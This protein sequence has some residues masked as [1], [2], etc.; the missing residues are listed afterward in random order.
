MFAAHS[1]S[2]FGSQCL[3]RADERSLDLR[4]KHEPTD[5][6]YSFRVHLMP[7]MRIDNPVLSRPLVDLI[8]RKA[9]A[10]G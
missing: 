10:Q 3:M 9:A 7:P 1:H 5:N 2:H 6:M 4:V 8:R